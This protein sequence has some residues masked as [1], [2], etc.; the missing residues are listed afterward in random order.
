MDLLNSEE[1][2]QG[3]FKSRTILTSI[4]TEMPCPETREITLLPNKLLIK[5][6][7]QTTTKISPF[8]PPK[9]WRAETA[10][11]WG[12]EQGQ[13]HE[14]GVR[15]FACGSSTRQTTVVCFSPELIKLFFSFFSATTKEIIANEITDGKFAISFWKKTLD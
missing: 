12:A 11:A 6:Y 14:C 9:L 15:S 13:A 8:P 10:A 3:L 7:F 5:F 1:F 4:T 2:L